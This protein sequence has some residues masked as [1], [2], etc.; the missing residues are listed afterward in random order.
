VICGVIAK[1]RTAL[2]PLGNTSLEGATIANRFWE[3][4]Q[5]RTEVRARVS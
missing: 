5:A 2:G 4:Y 1:E 3:L